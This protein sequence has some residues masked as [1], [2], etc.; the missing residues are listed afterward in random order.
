MAGFTEAELRAIIREELERALHKDRRSE[1]YMNVR[2]MAQWLNINPNI[3]RCKAQQGEWPA[4]RIGS[5][6]HFSPEHQMQIERIIEHRAPR[7]FSK[8]SQDRITAALER[9]SQ[10]REI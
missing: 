1:S 6:F 5:R 9:L 2:E 8:E 3:V 7:P 4:A 10:T